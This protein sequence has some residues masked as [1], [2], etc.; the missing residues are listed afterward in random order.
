MDNPLTRSMVSEYP[1]ITVYRD[2]KIFD[3]FTQC[4]NIHATGSILWFT[5]QRRQ[6]SIAFDLPGWSVEIEMIRRP[7]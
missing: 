1:K 7:Q 6:Q 5:H 3:T 2:G 4:T